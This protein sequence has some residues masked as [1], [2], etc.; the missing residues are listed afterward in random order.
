MKHPITQT[1][2]GMTVYIDLIQSPA[3]QHIAT[4]PRLLILVKEVLQQTSAKAA[5]VRLEKDMGRSIGYDFVA[6]ASDNDT[7]FYAQV[8]RDDTYTR[9]VKNAAPRTTQFLTII[10]QRDS[11]GEYELYDSWIGRLSPPHPGSNK[12][13]TDSKIY[14]A[15]HAHILNGQSL[16][17]RT[18][19][20][21]CP[22]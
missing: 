4:Q 15:N 6:E 20:K 16:Q 10:L 5:E 9:F 12:E 19:T 8:A 13:T 11:D 22:Y 17:L 18:V 21:V 3:A 2:N 1:R 7:I 14:W